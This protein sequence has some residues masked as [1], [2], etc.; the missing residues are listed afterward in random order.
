MGTQKIKLLVYSS[1][2][3]LGGAEMHTMRVLNELNLDEFEV[4]VV[5]PNK[6]GEYEQYLNKG[7]KLIKVGS[8]FLYEKSSTIGRWSTYFGL[9]KWINKF[10]PDI[11]FSIQDIHNAILLKALK[12]VKTNAKIVIG[13]QNSVKDAYADSSNRVNRWIMDVIKKEYHTVDLLISL[14]E[15]VKEGLLEVNP[16]LR[17]KIITIY[18][19]GIDDI[20]IEKLKDAQQNP[21]PRPE[22]TVLLSAGRLNEQKGYPVLLKALKQVKE[23]GNDFEHWILGKGPLE[24]ELKELT[25]KYGLTENVK[26]LGFQSNPFQFM[27]TADV[28][29][30]SSLYE[31]FGNVI[32]EAM[33][34]GTAVVSTDCPHGPSEII[35][36]EDS[37]YLVAVNDSNSLALGIIRLI[38]DKD[39][40][41]RIA[42]NG[43]ERAN[44]FHSKLI[45]EQY[46]KAFKNVLGA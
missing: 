4:I 24:T 32:V 38:Q 43:K 44:A 36:H 29:V 42:I 7:I 34:C 3:G 8:A 21:V 16:Q 2:L 28:F 19:C 35:N 9:K 10:N 6:V 37:G 12:S 20:L 41:D 18:N 33:A 26:Y 31:G 39:L 14:S 45:T 23:Q 46:T 17:D 27:A 11:I 22:K 1:Y 30:L 40:R 25:E 15:G 5:C 13:V